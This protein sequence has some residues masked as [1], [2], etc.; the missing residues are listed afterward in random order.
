[1]KSKIASL[2]AFCLFNTFTQAQAACITA[3][4]NEY[5]ALNVSFLFQQEQ[6]RNILLS[7]YCYDFH[8]FS[9]VNNIAPSLYFVRNTKDLDIF[10]GTRVPIDSYK[11]GKYQLDVLSYFLLQLNTKINLTDK[12]KNDLF[13]LE[14]QYYPNVSRN[15]LNIQPLSYDNYSTL[16]KNM[17]QEYK[18]SYYLPLNNQNNTPLSFAVV[19][20]EPQVLKI[21]LDANS[22]RKAALYRKNNQG[23]TA[24]HLA[25]AEKKPILGNKNN[26]NEVNDILLDNL[27]NLK[28]NY[29]KVENVSF[30]EF[31]ELFKEHNMDFYQKLHKKFTYTITPERLKALQPIK[32]NLQQ[33]INFSKDIIAYEQN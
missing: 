24:F 30:L 25:F 19:S 3:Q 20:N 26:I 14:K 6:L 12:D 32:A 22:N 8:N 1:M 7:K 2:I 33:R 16:L 4:K 28:L 29:L 21:L 17:A 27:E 31:V 15:S 10:T 13:I 9:K 23:I 18:T 11:T 5:V